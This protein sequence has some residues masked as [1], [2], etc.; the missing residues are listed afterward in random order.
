VDILA[1]LA[2]THLFR[3]LQFESLAGL[4]KRVA[5]LFEVHSPKLPLPLNLKID[6]V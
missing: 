2:E 5:E 4:Q 6:G 1:G 3:L